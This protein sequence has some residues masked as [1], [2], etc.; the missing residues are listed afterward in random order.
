MLLVEREWRGVGEDFDAGWTRVGPRITTLLAA[1][2]VG[3]AIDGAASVPVA[4]EQSGYPLRQV[5]RVSPAA[6]AGVA[7]DGRRLDSLA[8][9]AV[10]KARA[11]D[12]TGLAGRLRAGSAFLHRATQLQVADA[13]RAASQV[14]IAATP[15]AGYVRHVNPPCCQDCAVLAGKF[16][17]HSAGFARH[18]G[19]D[20]VHRP[21]AETEP[22]RGYAVQ[23][24]PAQ[25]KDLT[26]GQR[27]ALGD[28][29]DLGRVV[30]AY[31]GEVPGRR[32]RM[33]A[34]HE[35]ATRGRVRLTPDGIL[36]GSSSREESIALLREHG[37]LI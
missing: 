33:S 12:A 13:G 6:F 8:Y 29:A 2:Q 34:T 4:L 21:T 36:A 18:P 31:R 22:P 23:I 11:V 32:D 16:F 26:A 20:C 24:D 27:A 15:G 5:A 17:R 35:L 25:I 19:C 14:A 10:V 28:G 3:A 9:G 1:A 37:Y 7:S 30:N